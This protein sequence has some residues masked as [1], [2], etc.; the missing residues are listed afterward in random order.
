MTTPQS[1]LTD[2]VRDLLAAIRDAL[3]IP[4]AEDGD[5][6]AQKQR[7]WLMGYRIAGLH[8]ALKATLEYQSPID[9]GV[10]A[11]VVRRGIADHPVTYQVHTPDTGTT[12]EEPTP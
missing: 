6:Q 9:I 5:D 7:A 11:S 12:T 4:Y 1:G 2:E 10:T 3:D 8:G